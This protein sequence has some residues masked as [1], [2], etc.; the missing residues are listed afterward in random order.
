MT[1]TFIFIV[2]IISLEY[3]KY[4]KIQKI[5]SNL[6][7]FLMVIRLIKGIDKPRGI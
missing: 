5:F 1:R 2:Y 6:S 7:Y 4:I 3:T